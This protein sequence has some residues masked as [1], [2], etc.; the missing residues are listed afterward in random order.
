VKSRPRATPSDHGP[1]SS[2]G[3]ETQSTPDVAAPSRSFGR[4]PRLPRA[5][6]FLG[7]G[8]ACA[9]GLVGSLTR[10]QDAGAAYLLAG[11]VLYLVGSI[12]VTMLFNVPRN[13]ALAAL[14][15]ASAEGAQ[16]WASY[17]AEWTAWN[18]VRTIASFA[19]AAV[20]T[21]ALRLRA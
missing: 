3:R 11:S 9:V 21:V 2:F 5:A 14:A 8:L 17:L 19:A 10:W 15:P 20:L 16:L 7:T 13:N 18:H 4:T 12:V 1:R 6:V